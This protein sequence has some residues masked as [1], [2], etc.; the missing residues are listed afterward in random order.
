MPNAFL[1]Q[2]L[3]LEM[4]LGKNCYHLKLDSFIASIL[5]MF[6]LEKWSQYFQRI[7]VNKLVSVV[8]QVVL[9]E[10]QLLAV[11][12][13]SFVFKRFLTDSTRKRIKKIILTCLELLILKYM[14]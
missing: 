7:V 2:F 4:L 10:P 5:K 12:N 1:V 11:G 9:H 3:V 14:N 13:G 6:D 8:F